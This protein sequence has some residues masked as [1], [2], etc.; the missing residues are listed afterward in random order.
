MICT[1]NI[2]ILLVFVLIN[3]VAPQFG[4]LMIPPYGMYP[5]AG[6]GMPLINPLGMPMLGAGGIGESD[7]WCDIGSANGCGCRIGRF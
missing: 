1:I 2:K 6:M 7:N 5:Y 3:D 4:S